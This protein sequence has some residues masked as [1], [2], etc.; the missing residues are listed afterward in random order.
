MSRVDVRSI[1]RK[2]ILD[3]AERL[4]VKRGWAEITILDICQEAGVSSGV[5]TYHF[6]SKDEIML[7]LLEEFI[8]RLDTHLNK[9][10]RGSKTPEED[11]NN[12]LQALT[13]SLE[14]DPHFPPLLIHF[15]AASLSRPEIAERLHALFGA[16]RERKIE[17]LRAMEAV[18]EEE[19]D[20]VLILVNMLHI[21]T[22]GVVLAR[23]ILG[24]DLP[25]ERLTEEARS[26]LL[27][28]FSSLK[29]GIQ[30]T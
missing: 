16:I 20:K 3:A 2:Q 10:V 24:I 18:G 30:E 8:G 19:K 1:R 27:M 4:A 17:E 14:D 13:M 11:I 22:L 5:L 9:A 12:F 29:R 6:Q 25:Y 28:C 26:L 21:V 15:V 23:P 7:A